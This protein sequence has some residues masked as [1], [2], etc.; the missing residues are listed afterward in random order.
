MRRRNHI[1]LR[2]GTRTRRLIAVLAI[3]VLCLTIVGMFAGAAFAES[4][5]GTITTTEGVQIQ[6][7]EGME[8][9]ELDYNWVWWSFFLTFGLLFVYY[10]MVLRIS[11]TE[12]KKIVD[13]H[14]GPRPDGR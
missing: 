7:S 11:N 3:T 10:V 1:G 9:P 5:G 13:A 2:P 6:T 12:F 14:F 8:A 4:E